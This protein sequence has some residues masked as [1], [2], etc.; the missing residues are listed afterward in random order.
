MARAAIGPMRRQGWGRIVNIAST[1]GKR[2]IPK[3]A[4]YTA[5]KHAVIGLT[6]SLAIDL[7]PDGITVNAVCPGQMYTSRARDSAIRTGNDDIDAEMARR[8][9]TIPTGR[10]GYPPDV[11]GLVCYLASE[12]ASFVTAQAISVD[13]G[14]LPA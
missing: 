14:A 1:A 6:R 5:S 12:A 4:A 13:G 3:Q 10:V 7:G 9:A 8:A 2:G 11:A